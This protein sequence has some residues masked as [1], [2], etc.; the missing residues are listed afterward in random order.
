MVPWKTQSMKEEWTAKSLVFAYLLDLKRSGRNH[1]NHKSSCWEITVEETHLNR[2]RKFTNDKCQ[3]ENAQKLRHSR[4]LIKAFQNLLNSLAARRLYHN[5]Q[6]GPVQYC[7]QFSRF[8]LLL[9]QT[10]TTGISP[11]IETW[12]K[13]LKP[14][15]I[16]QKQTQLDTTE[17]TFLTS[18][19][20]TVRGVV[21]PN[22]ALEVSHIRFF[23]LSIW[24]ISSKLRDT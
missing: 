22:W 21:G 7:R 23:L 12:K 9:A 6:R 2:S 19:Q 5:C 14:Q 16:P 4:G 3:L 15:V 13:K 18:P 17:S 11:C 8:T 10:P 20:H 24:L 1:K